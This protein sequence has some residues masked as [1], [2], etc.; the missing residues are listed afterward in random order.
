[1]ADPTGKKT[2]R[3]QPIKKST[4]KVP[5][6]ET[7]VPKVSVKPE[8]NVTVIDTG[9]LD[10]KIVLINVGSPEFRASDD[11]IKDVRN[12]FVEAIEASNIEANCV[13]YV[14]DHTVR[15]SILP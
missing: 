14:G 13:V 8:Q 10:G 7:A 15:I 4:K 3:K 5:K 12:S 2:V 1:M 11:D 6:K 9:P